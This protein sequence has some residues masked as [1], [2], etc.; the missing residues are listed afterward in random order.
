MSGMALATGSLRSRLSQLHRRLAPCRSRLV[1]TP[2]HIGEQQPRIRT[3]PVR[4]TFFFLAAF[5][6]LSIASDQDVAVERFLARL[7]LVDLQTHHLEQLVDGS[8][9]GDERRKLA[10]RLADLYSAQLIAKSE[11]KPA[12][13]QVLQRI[14]RLVERVPEA[15]TASLE[16]MLLQA[17]YFRAESLMSK[18]MADRSEAAAR[19]E[20]AQIL[21]RI[22][23]QLDQRQQ[24]LNSSV[25]KLVAELDAGKT[26][27]DHASKTQ[28]LN[29]VQ[30]V[31]GRASFFAAWASYYLAL[32]HA[33]A[34]SAKPGFVKARDIFRHILG[35][36][37][38]YSEIDPS[39]LGLESIWRAR[40]LI[41]LGLAEAAQG[42]IDG[43]RACFDLL[44][45]SPAPSE[46][47][48][49]SPYW[50]VQSL[51]NAGRID[52]ALAFAKPFVDSFSGSA[53]QGRVSFCLSLVRVGFGGSQ[54]APATS[55]ELGMLGI[56]GLIKLR[57][58]SA[59]RQMIDKYK[60]PL[61]GQAGFHLTW[62]QGQQLL[63][64]AEKSKRKEDYESAAKALTAAL[65]MQ[66][67]SADLA[68]SSQCR[69]QLAWCLYKAGDVEKGARTYEMAI[70][71]LKA[72]DAK[73]AAEAAWMAFICYQT[74]AKSDRKFVQP[75][76][77]ILRALQRDFPDHPYAKRAEYYAGKL[78]Q[79]ALPTADA[80]A[81]LERVLATSPEY[82][83]ARFDICQLLYEQWS[84]PDG[85]RASLGPKVLAAVNQ[86]LE[87][88]KSDTDATRLLRAQLI[89]IDVALNGT[90]TDEIAAARYLDR[91]RR[92]IDT[93]T[94]PALQAE[95]HYRSIQL[96]ARKKDDL[97]R[98]RH[99]EW[100][101]K[102][103]PGS[104]FELPSLIIAA[105]TLDHQVKESA[106]PSRERLTEGLQLYQRLVERL[107]DDLSVLQSKK[108]A[109]VAVSRLAH[110]LAELGQHAEATQ[111]LTKL[112]AAFP[113][114]Q[115]YLRRAGLSSF[116]AGDF[117]ASSEHWRKLVAGLPKDSDEW[118][119]A[120]YYQLACLEKLDRTKAREAFAQFRLLFPELGPPAWRGKFAE[121]QQ[122]VE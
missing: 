94:S 21:T 47:R 12:Y 102:N 54:P 43:S 18:W 100:I 56:T 67:A 59:V 73:T 16:V 39:G 49:L 85:D 82:L 61:D 92:A 34:E 68:G 75:A 109:Q 40:T 41:G 80:L 10:E 50:R 3:L 46:L 101:V 62:L 91:A 90:P 122:R 38:N 103:A 5:C 113:T 25:D 65:A 107:G 27:D 117:A 20:A 6:T 115:T 71:G 97:A 24:Q 106:S 37:G 31:T 114:D 96:A 104:A 51:L 58:Q 76:V 11:D 74:L 89:G 13:D 44:D 116:R 81:N 23:P 78:Q 29:R 63:D 7:G 118:Y 2:N 52:E 36:D 77:N 121:L 35:V 79:T 45:R 48:E 86:F 83:A 14:H 30:A 33:N 108:N 53:S 95:Y 93:H 57:Q 110:Y 8:P 72:T 99:A 60:I 26:P 9:A 32:T 105:K 84:K 120:K 28:E 17:D 66:D 119:E 4:W 69:Y 22:T 64:T 19:D 70:D 15:K 87:A 42:N 55:R 88:A 112:L 111:A 1:V 98:Q